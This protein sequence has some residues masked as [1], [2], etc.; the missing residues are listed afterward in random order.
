MFDFIRYLPE[1]IDNAIDFV[2]VR[3]LALLAEQGYASFSLGGAPMSDVGTRRQARLAERV[4]RLFSLRAEGLFNFKGL[5]RYKSKFHPQWSPRYLAYPKPWDW[6]SALV[7]YVRLV[8][9]G[10]REARGRIAAARL[11]RTP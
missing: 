1:A 9:A 4:M 10:S 8:Q 5:Q 3:T 6:A 11:G 7:A 2:I